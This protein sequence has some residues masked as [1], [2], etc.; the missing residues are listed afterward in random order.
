MNSIFLAVFAFIAYVI[1]YNTYGRYLSNKIFK[2]DRNC[3]TPAHE[4]RDNR[5]YVPG[6]IIASH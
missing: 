6:D 1:A 5:D 4:L 2:L 3:K